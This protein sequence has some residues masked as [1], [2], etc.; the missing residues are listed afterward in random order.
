MRY[1]YLLGIN[2]KRSVPTLFCGPTGTGKSVYTK[3]LLYSLPRN[4]FKILEIGFSAQTKAH[5]I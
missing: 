2:L 3:N 4:E 1:K 5:Q